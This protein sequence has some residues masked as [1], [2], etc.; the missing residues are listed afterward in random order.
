LFFYFINDVYETDLIVDVTDHYESKRLSLQA[1]GTQ[2]LP[3]GTDSKVV[4]TP[5]NQGYLER[6]EARDLLMGQKMGVS[7][8]EGFVSKLPYPVHLF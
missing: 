6:V 8:A 3:A 1:Y 4:N 2:F 7:Y 5:L